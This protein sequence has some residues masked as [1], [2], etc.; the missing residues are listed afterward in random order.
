M[1]DL[2]Q[3]K[4]SS[5]IFKFAIPML[6]GNVFQQLYNVINSIIVG[7]YVSTD[8]LAAVGASFYIIFSISALVIGIT[9]GGSVVVSQLFGAKQYDKVRRA[10]DTMNIFLFFAAIAVSILGWFFSEDLFRL[11]GTKEHIIPMAREYFHISI[12]ATTIPMFGYNGMAAMLRGIGNSKTPLYFL[13][14]STLINIALDYLFVLYFGWSVAGV[15]WATFISISFAWIALYV[16]LYRTRSMVRVSLRHLI[17]DR[18]IFRQSLRIGLPSGIQQTLVGVGGVVL[19]TIVNRFG[20]NV[21]PAY[22]AA[23]RVDMF[24]AMPAMNFAAALSG[25]VGQNIGAGRYDRVKRGLRATLI[26]SNAT[27]IALTILIVFFGEHIMRLFVDPSVPN[28]AEVVAIGHEYLIIIC[29]FYFLFCT[30]FTLN[31]VVRGA[32]ATFIPMFITL[33]SL[34]LVRVPVAHFLS[35]SMGETGIWWSIP[36]GWAC[37]C[38]GAGIYYLSGRWKKADVIHKRQAPEK[39]VENPDVAKDFTARV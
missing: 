6:I 14:I 10:S 36:I 12:L 39:D 29:S 35:N 9:I 26:M 19:L 30:M 28:S 27:C 24:I 1:K 16:Y 23:G 25:F 4:E 18:F 38:I 5:V 15:A 3:G 13:A 31:G 33:I 17:F 20:D 34:W 37:G 2:T 22:I 7:K 21:L 11:M 32:G 8:A